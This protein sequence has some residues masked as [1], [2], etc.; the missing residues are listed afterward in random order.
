LI[1][2]GNAGGIVPRELSNGG[3][4]VKLISA[5]QQIQRL[6]WGVIW[7]LYI[8][9]A[10]TIAAWAYL[11]RSPRTAVAILITFLVIGGLTAA[12]TRTW[13]LFFLVQYPIC[14]LGVAFVAYTLSFGIPAGSILAGIVAGASFEEV[15]GFIVTSQ[16][17]SLAYLLTGWTAC[18]LISAL[19]TPTGAIF[20]R[21][22]SLARR[23]AFLLLVPAA[24]YAA[25]DPS[26]L[27]EGIALE[28]VAGGLK[29]IFVDIPQ[30]KADLRLPEIHKIPYQ[31]QRS[32]GE[33]V[34]I[35]IIGESARRD[36]WSVYGYARQTTPYLESIKSE[37]V[38]FQNAVADA[39]FT[40][41][42]VPL[43]L[44]GMTPDSFEISKVRG[45]IFDLARESG[46]T[47]ILLS[48]Q[49]PN[50]AEAA[51]VD[52]DLIE[53]PI[54]FNAGKWDRRTLDG[55]LLPAFHREMAKSGA[56]RFIALH[57]MGSHSV[58]SNRYPETFSRFGAA[59]HDEVSTRSMILSAKDTETVQLDTY[60]NSVAYTDWL[61]QQII[62][63]AR[64]LTVPVTVTFF[65]DHGEGLQL[66]DGQA[67]HGAPTYTPSAFEVPAFVWTNNAY[68]SLHPE[69]IAALKG[70]AAKEVRSHNVFCTVADLMGIRWPNSEAAQSFAS[71]RFVPDIAMKHIA[72]GV[73]VAS[74]QEAPA[75]SGQ[76]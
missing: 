47:P 18:Y 3:Y 5:V 39:N 56:A 16:G 46:Y 30:Y 70:N 60:D 20:S 50:A 34:H 24:A 2:L 43:M 54:D 13:R 9:P 7:T 6:C 4:S 12:I 69:I 44:T 76:Y 40:L 63:R 73:L 36:S 23:M 45:N 74:P 41:R 68:R 57:I 48:N 59:N 58:Y 51:G 19:I 62:E 75:S 29:F 49:D 52:P 14:L 22:G 1:C 15:A 53:S 27:I 10:V 67:G 64:E 42:S 55:E 11:N 8:A 21:A 33:E 61:L 17:H 71:S 37:A 66:L 32:G 26:Q 25:T 35:L 28:P 31:A 72:G 65:A 38:F